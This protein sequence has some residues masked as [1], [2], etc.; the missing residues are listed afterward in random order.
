MEIRIQ[1]TYPEDGTHNMTNAQFTIKWPESSGISS[2]TAGSP[3]YPF[4][5][6][7]QG[8]P[9]TDNGYYYQV[10]SSSGGN[11][12]SWSADEEIVVQTFTYTSPPCPLFEIADD[13]YVNTTIDGAYYFEITGSNKTGSIYSASAQVSAPADA[14]PITGMDTVSNPQNGVIYSVPSIAYATDYVWAYSGTGVTINGNTNTITIAFSSTATGGTLTVKGVNACGEGAE[15]SLMI[16][17]LLLEAEQVINIQS[18]WSGISSYIDAVNDSVAVLFEP[19][20]NDLTILMGFSQ[21]Y[22][23]EQGINTIGTWNTHQGYKIKVNNGVQLTFSGVP[24]SI[25]TLNLNSGWTIIPVLNNT[26][27]NVSQLFDPLGD[28]LIIVKEIAGNNLYWPDQSIYTLVNLMPGKAYMVATAAVCS[29]TFPDYTPGPNN[30]VNTWDVVSN[31]TSWNDVY[32]TPGSHC[33]AIDQNALGAV[34]PGDIIGIFNAAGLCCGMTEVKDT[35]SP[36][37]LMAFG[38]DVTTDNVAD[39]LTEGEPMSLKLYRP[40]TFEE[41]KIFPIFEQEQTEKGFFKT[42]GLSKISSLTLSSLSVELNYTEDCLAFYPNPTDGVLFFTNRCLEGN[43][44]V[45]VYNNYGHVVI[46]D[47][48]FFDTLHQTYHLDLTSL[49]EG[50]YMVRLAGETFVWYEKIVVF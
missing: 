33:I 25:K 19:I 38:D 26:P 20:I 30:P 40:E 15:S 17:V 50:V 13:E 39:G 16:T 22:W 11:P 28:T 49:R 4:N 1:P 12:V 9:T 24:D 2:I 36:L 48:L 31:I 44:D 47:H 23:P 35:N 45:K 8:S 14:G 5:F 3:V 27:V 34:K 43:A 21:V 29:V 46:E 18:G 41:F 32:P 42:D 37:G 10:F 7:P 6:S